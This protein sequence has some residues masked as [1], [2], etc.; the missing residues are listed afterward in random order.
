[1]TSDQTHMRFSTAKIELDSLSLRR[2]DRL[3]IENLSLSLKAGD[4]LYLT[5]QNGVGK[6][7][8]LLAL[9][10]FLRPESG[11]IQC[12]ETTL[13]Q[14]P[15]GASKGLSVQEDLEFY[16]NLYQKKV[17]ACTELERVGLN[18][19]TH[20]L[21]TEDLSLGQ[22][23]RLNL[24]KIILTDRPIWLLDEP[25]S[26]LDTEGQT[27]V[28]DTLSRHLSYGGIAVIATHLPRKIKD[29]HHKTLHL[30]SGQA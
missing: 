6:T 14:T 28:E 24:A 20:T 29:H 21:K 17:E 25:F 19:S 22:R 4:I 2:G 3:L 23:K 13:M 5:G 9:A 27:L 26:A 16:A 7:T 10:G 15:D 12:A 8:L 1:M 18:A 30:S 11:F